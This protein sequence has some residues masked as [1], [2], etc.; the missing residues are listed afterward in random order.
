METVADDASTE[1]S[2]SLAA[3]TTN[4]KYTETRLTTRVEAR[5]QEQTTLLGAR[6]E[7]Q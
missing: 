1:G 2:S 7:V 3:T 6:G 4:G 5:L